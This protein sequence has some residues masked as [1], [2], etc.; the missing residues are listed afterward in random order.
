MY[1]KQNP[2]AKILPFYYIKENHLFKQF[3]KNLLRRWHSLS[4]IQDP[5]SDLINP[6]LHLHLVSS[7]RAH[8][9]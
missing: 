2:K 9:T 5:L 8:L 4:L 7:L 6:S 1:E 3:S